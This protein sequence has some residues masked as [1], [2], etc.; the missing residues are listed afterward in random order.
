VLPPVTIGQEAGWTSELV[1]SQARGETLCLCRG[2]L[3]KYIKIT[4]VNNN[5]N[6]N[7]NNNTVD[8]N[9]SSEA[10]SGPKCIYCFSFTV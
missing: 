2:L 9:A 6:N 7:N 1:W 3:R 5:N 4:I 8:I 10:S